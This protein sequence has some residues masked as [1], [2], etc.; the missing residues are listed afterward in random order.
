MQ[1]NLSHSRDWALLALTLDSSIGVDIE[2]VKLEL[3]TDEIA[4][5]F[6]SP[7]E[8]NT[9]SGL[10]PEERAA[11]FFS[12]WTRKE[13]YIKAVGEGLSLA[14]DTFDVAFGPGVSAGLL[15]VEASPGELS[16][17]ALYDVA[18]P[19]GYAAALAAEGKHHSLHHR[20]WDWEL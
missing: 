5:S 3:K 2:F 6:F 7:A 20:H 1:F 10:R 17:W 18:A 11:A 16:R 15:R 9:L 13:A 12:C 19:Q 8:L 14:L 4:N